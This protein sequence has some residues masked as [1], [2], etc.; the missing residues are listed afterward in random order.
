MTSKAKRDGRIKSD[1]VVVGIDV[2]SF[3]H[4][5]PQPVRRKGFLLY[6]PAG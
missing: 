5:T 4:R 1:I 6:G 2:A 3:V